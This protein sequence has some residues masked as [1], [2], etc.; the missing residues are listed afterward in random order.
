MTTIVVGGH[1][2]NV[3]KTSVA[4]GLIRAFNK[5]PWTAIKITSHWHGSTPASSGRERENICDIYEEV[6]REGTSDTSRYLAAGACRALWV[7]IKDDPSGASLQPLLPILQSCPFAIIESNRIVNVIRPDLFIMVLRYD[8]GEFKDSA[9][10]A[11]KQANAA[12]VV[13][14]NLTQP[15]WKGVEPEALSN[16]PLFA[17]ADP[18]MLPQGFL[19]FVQSRLPHW[20]A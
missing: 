13:N 7:R 2:R 19:D 20:M 12:V 18:R 3:G 15:L 1:S 4:A 6:D 5:Y 9:L 11:L 8:I 17:T 16:I 14:S 10:R